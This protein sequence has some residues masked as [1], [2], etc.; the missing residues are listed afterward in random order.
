MQE[1]L[2]QTTNLT[3]QFGRHRAVD[4]VN[5]HIKKG[6]IYGLLEEMELEKQPVSK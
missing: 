3:K 2:L 6:S 1:I 5:L 4:Q